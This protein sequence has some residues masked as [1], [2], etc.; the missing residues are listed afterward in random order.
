[1]TETKIGY[2]NAIPNRAGYTAQCK[3]TQV[4]A[5]IAAGRVYDTSVE[6]AIAARRVLHVKVS[7]YFFDTEGSQQVT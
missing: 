7:A 2:D 4:Q 6:A 3:E 1:M 5:T